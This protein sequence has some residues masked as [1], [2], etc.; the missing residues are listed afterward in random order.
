VTIGSRKGGSFALV[1]RLSNRTSPVIYRMCVRNSTT[2]SRQPTTAMLG[3]TGAF[4]ASIEQRPN[5]LR[6]QLADSVRIPTG[7]YYSLDPSPRKASPSMSGTTDRFREELRGVAKALGLSLEEAKVEVSRDLRP[8][9]PLFEH[10]S[11]CENRMTGTIDGVPAAMFDLTTIDRRRDDAM[12]S[13]WTVIQYSA[14]HFPPFVCVPRSLKTIPQRANVTPI[15]FDA[16]ALDPMTR[17][18][19]AALERA[20]VLGIDDSLPASAEDAIR[21]FF[22]APRLELLARHPRWHIQSSGEVVIFAVDG[23]VPAADRPALWHEAAGIRRALLSLRSSSVVAIPS[24]PGMD[25]GRQR[26]RRDGRRTGCLAGAIAGFFIGFIA[27]S[28]FMTG[29]SGPGHH[30]LGPAARSLWTPFY[31][32]GGIAGGT[33][34][35]ALAGRW[36]GGRVAEQAFN[37]AHAIV[38]LPPISKAWIILG[39]SLGWIGGL[40]IGLIVMSNI[41]PPPGAMWIGPILFFSPGAVFFILG[42]FAGLAIARSRAARR[43]GH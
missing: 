18:S 36:L 34:L 35:T 39:A 32:F 33:L 12:S 17:D 5:P 4:H 26:A 30:H 22:V 41:Q 11:D 13:L 10:W 20:Y 28:A 42:G 8:V 37:P 2:F 43:S 3:L 1:R 25:I 21:H 9:V 40:V 29:R 23:I 14:T 27:F 19:L 16:R 7:T 38:V 31:F 24:V 6:V 15:S